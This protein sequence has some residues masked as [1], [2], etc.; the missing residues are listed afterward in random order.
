MES[1][2]LTKQRTF[3]SKCPNQILVVR[4]PRPLRD[5]N[6]RQYEMVP[7]LS[8]DFEGNYFIADEASAA[9]V[10]MTMDELVAWLYKHEMFNAGIFEDAPPETQE[11]SIEVQSKAIIGAAMRQDPDS[12]QALLEEERATHDRPAVVHAAVAALE[13]IAGEDAG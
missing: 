3:F 9:K 6:G 4:Q 13:S 11:P 12:I 2:T 5:E 1:N 8:I 10:G 7:Q